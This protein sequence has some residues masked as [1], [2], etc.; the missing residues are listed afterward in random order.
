MAVER[1]VPG[2][3]D[4]ID[5]TVAHPARRYNYWLGGKDNFQADRESGDAIAAAF[6]GVRLGAVENRRFLRRAVT[7]LV[8]DAGIDQFLDVGT[9]IPSADNTHEVAQAVDASTRVVYVDNDPIVLAHARA[10][11]NSASEGAT[12]YLD[13]DLRDPEGILAHPDLR[14]TLDLSRPVALML[15]AVLHF[16]RDDEDPYGLVRRL[17][18]ALPS[19]SY[20][21]MSHV[22]ADYFP[23]EQARAARGSQSFGPHGV[24]AFRTREEFTRFFDGLEILD[25]G[26]V[27]VAEWR[28]GDEPG[29]R[30]TAAEAGIHCAVA[31]KP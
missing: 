14:A 2:G 20:L 23:P 30:P 10:L 16:V 7:H 13:A 8:R 3:A 6:P 26:V 28:S 24:M 29:V 5:T 4:R 31:R 27:S 19:G 11:L 15:V 9:G 12:A 1:T 18:D 22:T 17:V 21:V 25:P